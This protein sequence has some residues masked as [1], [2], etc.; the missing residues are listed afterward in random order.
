MPKPPPHAGEYL[1]QARELVWEAI[2]RLEEAQRVLFRA[3]DHYVGQVWGDGV[4]AVL[5]ITERMADLSGDVTATHIEIGRL[6]RRDLGRDDAN[7][8]PPRSTS[9]RK[10]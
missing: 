2:A 3:G 6:A 10:P 5:E 1:E 4:R 9:R 7:P 8:P